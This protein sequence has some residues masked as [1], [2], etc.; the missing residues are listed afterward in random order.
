[1][2]RPEPDSGRALENESKKVRVAPREAQALRLNRYIEELSTSA[3]LRRLVYGTSNYIICLGLTCK[4]TLS[5]IFMGLQLLHR[6][7]LYFTAEHNDRKCLCA[8]CLCLAWKHWEDREGLRHPHKIRDLVKGMFIL[9]QSDRFESHC[10]ATPEGEE[11]QNLAVVEW[12]CRDGGAEMARMREHVKLYESLILR[13]LGFKIVDSEARHLTGY[14]AFAIRKLLPHSDLPLEDFDS[15]QALVLGITL[16]LYRWPVCLRYKVL[17]VVGA[18]TFK[19]AVAA[20]PQL[21][22]QNI[23][24][25]GAEMPEEYAELFAKPQLSDILADI[26]LTYEWT[27]DL[28]PEISPPSAACNV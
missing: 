24:K 1:M 28:V 4:L 20:R 21:L 9:S 27:Q 3:R 10:A 22:A 25:S 11:A 19:A 23:G 2:K 7:S 13:A 17:D 12:A 26:R 6:S 5:T 16:D 18:A 14:L 8:A 15:L